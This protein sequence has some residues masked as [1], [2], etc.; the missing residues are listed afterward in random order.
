MRAL[1]KVAASPD[2]YAIN[3]YLEALGIAEMATDIGEFDAMYP[4]ILK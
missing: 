1:P 4:L 2:P 3:V